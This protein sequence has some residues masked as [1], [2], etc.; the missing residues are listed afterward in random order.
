M[1]TAQDQSLV[2]PDQE[3]RTFAPAALA[4]VAS[5]G[6]GAIH[7]TAVGLHAEHRQS[8]VAFALLAAFQLGWGALALL[9]RGRLLAVVGAVGN[10][11]AVVGWAVAK[12][13]GIGFIDGLETAEGIQWAD[14]LAALL[15]TVAVVGA[16]VSIAPAFKGWMSSDSPGAVTSGA[17]SGLAVG[18]VAVSVVGMVAAGGHDHAAGH[19]HGATEVVAG[20]GHTHSH[21]SAGSGDSAAA[22]S[23]G[24]SSGGHTHAAAVVPP[25]AYDPTKPIDLGGVSGVSLEQQARA[26]NLIALTLARLPQWS[27]YHTAEAKGFHS[28]GDGITGYEHFVNWSFINDKH[29]LDPDHPESLVYSTAG[30]KRKLVSAMFMLPTNTTLNDVPDVGGKLTQWHIHDNLCFTPTNPPAVAGVTSS[31]GKCRP[32]LRNLDPVPMIHVWIVSHPCGPF[33][34]LEGVGAGQI[35]AGETRLCDTAHGAGTGT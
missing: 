20:D 24:T 18:L 15:A 13:K 7:C 3:P 35:K 31:G 11:V 2:S 6:A 25:K 9:R 32:P 29:T 16:L 33:A 5:L 4:G 19:S 23:G 14:G 34:A 22:A 8:A 28:I 21:A 1:V 17:V 30:G 10:G 27:D 26:E 12:T